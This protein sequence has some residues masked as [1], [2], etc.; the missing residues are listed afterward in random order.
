MTDLICRGLK[1]RIS[2]DMPQRS[3]QQRTMQSI[4]P[5][6]MFHIAVQKEKETDSLR[7]LKTR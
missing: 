7:E 2:E 1:S 3:I 4:L 6:A 5:D